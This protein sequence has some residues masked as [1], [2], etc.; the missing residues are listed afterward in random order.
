MRGFNT[1][2]TGFLK[3]RA[4]FYGVIIFFVFEALWI[5]LSAVYPMAF[6]EDFHFGVIKIY[7][8]QWLPFLNGQPDD[9]MQFGALATDPS[10]LYHYLM[11][12]PYRLAAALTDSQSAQ[13]IFLRLINIAMAVAGLILFKKVLRKA[14]ISEAMANASILIFA[15]IPIAPL[16]AGQ[17]NYDNL[18]FL[19]LAWVCL[20]AIKVY[21]SLRRH[22]VDA[23]AICSLVLVCLAASLVKYAFLPFALAAGLF[24]VWAF[25]REFS[26]DWR[27]IHLSA[28]AG[29]RAMSRRT[30]MALCVFAVIICGLFV[31]RY[32]LNLVRYHTPVPD[33]SAV[34]T[35]N[36]CM[37][38][39]PWARNYVLSNL[40]GQNS[41][42]TSPFGYAWQW[43][44]SMHYRLFFMINGPAD[45]YRNYPPVPLPAAAAVVI[46]L[47]G[48]AALALY[49]RRVFRNNVPLAFLFGL[50]AAYCCVL[51]LEGYSQ[52]VE[53][54]QPVAINGRYLLPVLLPLAAVY[55]KAL[56][57]VL[58]RHNK[59]KTGIVIVVLLMFL[60][61]GGFFSF[62]LRSNHAWYWPNGAVESTNNA[63]RRVLGPVMVEG[64]MYYF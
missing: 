33:C 63:A 47:S 51:W 16:L 42:N 64:V 41:V 38:Y 1:K 27:K 20:L 40:K 13:V 2:F 5:A 39:G 31:Q 52:F 58:G 62:I 50:S 7:S 32:G 56:G 36:D 44:Q 19:L 26:H 23:T 9:S 21:E 59:A 60:Q 6:D 57:A 11:S 15:L 55:I 24:I 14:K 37:S 18:L 22:R 45:S 61:G 43:L 4:F 12:F 8:H 25:V 17:V 35:E 54:G 3:S 46:S 29:F 10:Y 34:L 28:A 49:W 30:A 53:T 48:T